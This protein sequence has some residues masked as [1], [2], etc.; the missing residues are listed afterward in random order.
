MA[1]HVVNMRKRPSEHGF[2]LIELLVVIIILGILSAVVVFAVRGAGDKGAA[3]ANA[4]DLKTIRTAEEAYCAKFGKY[5]SA[6]DLVNAQ[7]LSELPKLHT[8]TPTGGGP[9]TGS[10]D[11]NASGFTTA[12]DLTQKCSELTVGMTTDQNAVTGQGASLGF[13]TP[14][15]GMWETLLDLDPNYNILPSLAVALPTL[16]PAGTNPT[17][18]ANATWRFNIRTGVTFHNNARL[19]PTR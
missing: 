15:S 11:Q 14:R 2:T 17:Y 6:Q 1:D 10:G 16:I 3:A 9:C 5:G 13:Q 7:L 18:P 8:A 19:T 12:C 4:T